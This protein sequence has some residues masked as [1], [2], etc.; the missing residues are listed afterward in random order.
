MKRLI[1]I[2]VLCLLY[3]LP[4]VSGVTPELDGGQTPSVVPEPP[5]AEAKDSGIYL[6][7]N[8]D[9]IYNVSGSKGSQN[10][11]SAKSQDIPSL[12][13]GT[14]Y[15]DTVLEL[16]YL[17]NGTS[18]PIHKGKFTG[19]PGEYHLT[20]SKWGFYTQQKRFFLKN[21]E[22]YTLNFKMTPLPESM[23]IRRSKLR[24]ERHT[25]LTFL[26]VGLGA[27]A[28]MYTHADESYNNYMAATEPPSAS[29]WRKSYQQ[30]ENMYNLTISL[31]IIPATWYLVTVLK[32]VVAKN[33]IKQEMQFGVPSEGAKK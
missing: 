25:A 24:F 19:A 11:S 3:T 1:V 10:N 8:E 6:A 27:A 21:N 14:N 17:A 16:M 9:Q 22:T 20:A 13:V 28:F 33:R 5:V 32:G 15:G 30:W 26:A 12:I 2:V 29:T 18:Y 23:M 31:N 7:L 4:A